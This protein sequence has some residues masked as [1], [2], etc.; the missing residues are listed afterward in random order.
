MKQCT[1]RLVSTSTRRSHL[2]VFNDD[3]K[4]EETNKRKKAKRM[5]SLRLELRTPCV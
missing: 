1:Q 2:D 3:C 5:V 4:K